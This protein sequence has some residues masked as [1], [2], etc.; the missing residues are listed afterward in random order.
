LGRKKMEKIKNNNYK[1]ILES[2]MLS[3][4]DEIT[5]TTNSI[6]GYSQLLTIGANNLTREQKECIEGISKGG[7]HLFE[8]VS[9]ITDILKLQFGL[10]DITSETID[11]RSLLTHVFTQCSGTA[12]R[13]RIDLLLDLHPELGTIEADR[14]RLERMLNNLVSN[15]LRFTEQ[16]H[17]VV[18][19]AE[20]QNGH[21]NMQIW[22]DSAPMTE[23]ILDHLFLPYVHENHSSFEGS[24]IQGSGIG[25]FLAGKMIELHN[26]TLAIE[27]S[28]RRN[29]FSIIFPIQ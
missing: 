7:K 5:I 10:L 29:I 6:L 19:S 11:V 27:T 21:V 15:I 3:L 16:E 14:T 13:R 8:I 28:T 26:G 25:M 20:A 22:N 12:F 1:K 17:K 24:S 9:V 18:I 23:E 2:S 4:G